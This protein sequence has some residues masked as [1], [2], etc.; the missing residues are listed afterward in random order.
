M[1]FKDVMLAMGLISEE[2]ASAGYSKTNLGME[3]AG[4]VTRVGDPNSKFKQGDRVVAF[5]SDNFS[6]YLLK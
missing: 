5:A 4:V 2:A 3:Y 6:T 1:N